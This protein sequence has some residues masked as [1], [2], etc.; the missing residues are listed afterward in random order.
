MIKILLIEPDKMLRQALTMALFP[1]FQINWAQK[2]P[3]SAP[4]GFDALII[5]A[6]ALREGEPM[7]KAA[8]ERASKWNLPM[9]WLES[10]KSPQPALARR[11]VRV[12]RP[13]TKDA[14]RSA[15][16]RCLSGDAEPISDESA[17]SMRA[18]MDAKRK[19]PN[20]TKTEGAGDSGNF[21]ELV[22]V[23]EEGIAR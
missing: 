12:N 22:D 18:A 6:A 5:D 8:I 21:I 1:D 20:S 16:A 10:G 7:P 23:V 2:L 3:D 11:C 13:L 4:R 15:L 19:Q 14:L 9:V 17:D